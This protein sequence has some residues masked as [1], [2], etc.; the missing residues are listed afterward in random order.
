MFHRKETK[1]RAVFL[2]RDGT[3]NCDVNH[4]VDIRN[5]RLISGAAKAI[6]QINNLGFVAVVVTNQSAI[7]HG[8]LTESKLDEIH[9]V[10]IRRLKRGGAKVDG[11]YYCPHH[12][13]GAVKKYRIKCRCRKPEPGMIIEAAK[14]HG[15]TAKGSFMVGDRTMDILAG[16]RA[17]L[18][19]ILVKT[20]MA[21]RDGKHDVK[22]DFAAKDLA[23]AVN[24]IKKHGRKN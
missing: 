10:M 7:A 19:T 1:K 14:K 3:I 9:A 2:D 6:R 16:K 23:D 21:G 24:V 17:K 4:I 8:W 13:K 11:I 22:A 5:F 20:G 18:K 12:V 15:I